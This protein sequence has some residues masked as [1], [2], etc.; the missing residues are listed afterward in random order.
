MPSADD[1][2][3]IITNEEKKIFGFWLDRQEKIWVVL[4]VYRLDSKTL[5]TL[6][7]W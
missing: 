2:V 6:F 3:I 5:P 1:D 4:T 7:L